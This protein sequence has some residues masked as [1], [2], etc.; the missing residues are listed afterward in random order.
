ME[1]I[2]LMLFA[3]IF[4]LVILVLIKNKRINKLENDIS[5]IQS[6]LVEIRRVIY[7]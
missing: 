4:I 1:Q 6:D 3:I 5:H 7:K 2:V